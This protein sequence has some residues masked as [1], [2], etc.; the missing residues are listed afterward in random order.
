[1]VPEGKVLVR[2]TAV[3]RCAHGVRSVKYPLT[4][5]E[6]TLGEKT[7]VVQAGVLDQLPV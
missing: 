1:M 6:I 5:L 3:V 4:K 2:E 7:M